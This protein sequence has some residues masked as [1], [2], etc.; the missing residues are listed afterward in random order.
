MVSRAL[1]DGFRLLPAR[2]TGST[3]FPRSSGNGFPFRSAA[4][5]PLPKRKRSLLRR[6]ERLYPSHTLSSNETTAPALSQKRQS[7]IL[8][9]EAKLAL[10]RTERNPARTE[11]C[12]RDIRTHDSHRPRHPGFRLFTQ[13]TRGR[14]SM[15]DGHFFEHTVNVPFQPIV[16]PHRPHTRGRAVPSRPGRRPAQH[17]IFLRRQPFSGPWRPSRRLMP[18]GER[19]SQERAGI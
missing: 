2:G 7:A 12:N 1:P 4:R 10:P 17:K 16:L 13:Q 11:A 18:E 15:P 14:F 3:R 19:T 6:T 8:R 5:F 9:D